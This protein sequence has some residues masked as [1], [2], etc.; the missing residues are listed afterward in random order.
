M[1]KGD[2][3]GLPQYMYCTWVNVMYM[4]TPQCTQVHSAQAYTPSSRLPEAWDADICR[5]ENHINSKM[6]ILSLIFR[7]KRLCR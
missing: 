6:Y 3:Q 2:R 7:Q 5:V 1:K 4:H